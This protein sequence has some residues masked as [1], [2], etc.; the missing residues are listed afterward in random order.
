MKKQ[1]SNMNNNDASSSRETPSVDT[2]LPEEDRGVTPVAAGL[3][4]LQST[5]SATPSNSF[6][7][8]HVALGQKYIKISRRI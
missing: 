6:T 4:S 1:L 3:N 5:L 8:K 2:E 7:N